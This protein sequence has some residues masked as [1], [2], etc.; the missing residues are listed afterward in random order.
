MHEVTVTITHSSH[1][2]FELF[3]DARFG[4]N[5]KSARGSRA[6][7]HQLTKEIVA[8]AV[9]RGDVLLTVDDQTV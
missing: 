8:A 4:T 7:I 9:A 2:D 1:P 5:Q 3:L 6:E